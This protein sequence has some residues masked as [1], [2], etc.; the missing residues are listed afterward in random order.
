MTLA[1]AVA[2]VEE[3]RS[4][5]ATTP[6]VLRGATIGATT[7]AG[8]AASLEAALSSARVPPAVAAS[9]DAAATALVPHSAY[10]PLISVAAA[11]EGVDP[12]LVRAVVRHESGFDPDATSRA[13]AMGLMQL[14]P[15]TARSLGV[16]DPYDPVQSIDGGTRFLRQLLERFGGDVRL[17]VAAYNA[18]P[19]A[20]ERYGGVPPYDETQRYVANVLA[21]YDQTTGRSSP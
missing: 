4:L 10:D 2:R 12:A 6:A 16:T 3:L 14:M 19:G 18:G 1:A 8:F 9:A 15:E 11:R 21:T 5:A 13:G 20:I 7:G 17:A